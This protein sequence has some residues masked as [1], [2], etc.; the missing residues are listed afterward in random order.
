[1]LN[2]G[3]K[4]TVNAKMILKTKPEL[5]TSL[6][7]HST[8]ATQKALIGISTQI[9]SGVEISSEEFWAE[10]EK[11]RGSKKAKTINK[12]NF[13]ERA[14]TGSWL[15]RRTVRKIDPPESLS[16]RKVKSGEP[17]QAAKGC[18]NGCFLV[19]KMLPDDKSSDLAGLLF[20]ILIHKLTNKLKEVILQLVFFLMPIYQ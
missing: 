3:K 10:A 5:S 1:M 17:A 14:H 12:R 16:E 13:Y 18:C 19:A 20:H 7:P 15:R 2:V 8:D 11:G 9:P 6:Q 4:G